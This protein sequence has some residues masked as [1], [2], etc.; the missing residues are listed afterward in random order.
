MISLEKGIENTFVK[1]LIDFRLEFQ[2][3]HTYKI[4][5]L[6]F[7]KSLIELFNKN[8]D[9]DIKNYLTNYA[10]QEFKNII[11]K[12]DEEIDL[13]CVPKLS[14]NNLYIISFYKK[15]E[16]LYTAC[17][18]SL[19]NN[20]SIRSIID[21]QHSIILT[22]KELKI[23]TQ[24]NNIN[25]HNLIIPQS[26]IDKIH[27]ND[28]ENFQ[29]TTKNI[30]EKIS[31][32]I[33]VRFLTSD[34]SYKWK[35]LS[36]RRVGFS[37]VDSF[38]YII[39]VK[40]IEY[41]NSLENDLMFLKQ[42]FER[43]TRI[44]RTVLWEVNSDGIFTYVSPNSELIWGL[45][46]EE[47]VGKIG[48]YDIHPFEEANNPKLLV[49]EK[50]KVLENELAFEYSY[51]LNELK[52]LWLFCFSSI[53]Y[54]KDGNF[55][56]YY[57]WDFDATDRKTAID[58]VKQYADELNH[59]IADLRIV[60]EHLEEQMFY[61][62]TLID[63]ISATKEELEKSNIEKDKFFSIIAHDLRSPFSG[64]LGLTN[65]LEENIDNLEPADLKELAKMLKDSANITYALLENLLEWSRIQRN[66]IKFEPIETNLYLLF[67]NILQLQQAN[68]EKKN[69]QVN[70]NLNKEILIDIDQNMINTVLRNLM[71]NA[72]KFTPK[73]GN[74]LITAN[75]DSE[76]VYVHIKDTGIG[77]P[78]S[79]KDNLF[80]IGAKTSREGT[81]GEASSGLGLLLCK[82]YVEMHKG[83]IWV[84]SEENAG[85]TFNFSLSK[86]LEIN[87]YL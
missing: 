53:D 17:V 3:D 19:L 24:I 48:F 40:D 13:I 62:N 64:F 55:L 57:G 78:D 26:L 31:K 16:N 27:P 22:D 36:M 70:L 33:D 42:K 28:R 83:K 2:E 5:I 39:V 66:V 86:K 79:I 41:I 12:F 6:Y 25:Y 21:N 51:Q 47:L 58:S 50:Q 43:L 14:N 18:E 63:E 23:L 65:M 38:F 71:S 8:D 4:D 77:I 35:R 7:S 67:S 1:G 84:E 30:N 10:L 85:S 54:D 9:Y 69:I 15:N 61:Q 32:S 49:F 73:N 68:L 87:K 60:Q 11:Y 80:N 76:F 46:P 37:I 45:R 44:T 72:V 59:A 81:D 82:E 75:E 74:I 20:I 29:F 56:S 52:K 34:N